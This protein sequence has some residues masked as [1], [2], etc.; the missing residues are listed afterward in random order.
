MDCCKHHQGIQVNLLSP[1]RVSITN[2]AERSSQGRD[3]MGNQVMFSHSRVALCSLPTHLVQDFRD[4]HAVLFQF[5]HS[6]AI[7]NPALWLEA[8]RVQG[9]AE[10]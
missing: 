1:S 3:E 2:V 5:I 4:R 9:F 7:R 10:F 8:A 6:D